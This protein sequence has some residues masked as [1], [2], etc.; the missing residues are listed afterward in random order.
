MTNGRRQT[1]TTQIQPKTETA[2]LS[3]LRST[4]QLLSWAETLETDSSKQRPTKASES[5]RWPLVTLSAI[6]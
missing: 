2:I 4:H 3:C 1:E 5:Y 6:S